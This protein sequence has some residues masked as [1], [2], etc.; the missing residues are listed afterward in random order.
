LPHKGPERLA[1]TAVVLIVVIIFFMVS[2]VESRLGALLEQGGDES[3][4]FRLYGIIGLA[5]EEQGDLLR[6]NGFDG[7]KVAP[8][9]IPRPCG[10]LVIQQRPQRR[11]NVQGS[12]PV[13]AEDVGV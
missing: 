7:R 9:N 11:G 2:M 13:V 1:I 8:K 4:G 6:T 12:A 3:R 5:K 10:F